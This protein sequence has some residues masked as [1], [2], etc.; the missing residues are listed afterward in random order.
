MILSVTYVYM[1]FVQPAINLILILIPTITL[2]LLLYSTHQ[3]TSNYYSRVS[4]EG[5]D[6]HTRQCDCAVFTTFRFQF[7]PLTYLVT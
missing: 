7:F 1:L 3:Q 5:N 4:Y 2:T 6:I